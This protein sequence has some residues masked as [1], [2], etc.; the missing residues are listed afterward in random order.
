MQAMAAR[1]P[2]LLVDA[3]RM[4]HVRGHSRFRLRA[5]TIVARV[6]LAIARRTSA[7]AQGEEIMTAWPHAPSLRLW[8]LLA[9]TVV[10]FFLGFVVVTVA[11]GIEAPML[12]DLYW[13][14]LI[15]LGLGH[16][17]S[18]VWVVQRH[19]RRDPEIER[20]WVVAAVVYTGLEVGLLALYLRWLAQPFPV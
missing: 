16:V 10:V 20:E 6:A 5:A 4:G 18:T 1:A 12:A 3:A 19:S 13:W 7:T 2:R 15:C 14:G 9:G 17:A 8:L 11:G